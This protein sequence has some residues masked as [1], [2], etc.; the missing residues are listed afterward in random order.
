VTAV[1]DEFF[2]SAKLLI[3]QNILFGILC[4]GD[5]GIVYNIAFVLPIVRG[6]DLDVL[7]V[8]EVVLSVDADFEGVAV[9]RRSVTCGVIYL[10]HAFRVSEIRRKSRDFLFF[11]DFFLPHARLDAIKHNLAR[12]TNAVGEG[13]RADSQRSKGA[14]GFVDSSE[15]HDLAAGV[16]FSF[17]GVRI[18][19]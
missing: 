5:R 9:G 4:F 8:D 17:H 15:L 12:P 10:F 2:H 16:V 13:E 1:N 11:Y 6:F 7:H 19:E 18:A 14:G 3:R